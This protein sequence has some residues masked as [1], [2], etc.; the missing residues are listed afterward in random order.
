MN[1]KTILSDLFD[2]L[3]FSNRYTINDDNILV[4]VNI[5]AIFST[6]GRYKAFIV[7]YILG[8]LN[9]RKPTGKKRNLR[10]REVKVRATGEIK[11]QVIENHDA[12][13]ISIPVYT[14]DL[15]KE[16]DAKAKIIADIGLDKIT[17]F[18]VREVFG[19]K[20]ANDV[21][22]GKKEKR[23]YEKY[24]LMAK[25]DVIWF[26]RTN[27]DI[28]SRG[29]IFLKEIIEEVERLNAERQAQGQPYSKIFKG[30]IK[31][32]RSLLLYNP[33]IKAVMKELRF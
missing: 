4:I 7:A 5:K 2:Y 16:A 32:V 15:L 17:Y 9:R 20:M 23:D 12:S 21:Y 3:H 33:D 24:D 11:M 19:E 22:V 27:L 1:S 26:L 31:F 30:F 18:I 10:Q 25:E 8:L 28:H 6:T 29:Y 14:E 13:Y